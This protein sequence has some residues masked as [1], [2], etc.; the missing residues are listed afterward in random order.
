M[1]LLYCGA[2]ICLIVFRFGSNGC[3]VFGVFGVVG[4]CA[5]LCFKALRP[6]VKKT[7]EEILI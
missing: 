4:L 6:V 1:G 7:K 5:D 3:L 2:V